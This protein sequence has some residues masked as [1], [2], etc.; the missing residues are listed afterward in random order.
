MADISSITLP[1][2]DTYNFKDPTARASIGNAV[3]SISSVDGQIEI[4][5]AD[6][7][8][9]YIENGSIHA[10]RITD[11]TF[12]NDVQ[13][14]ITQIAMGT[15]ISYK[16]GSIDGVRD[17]S[18]MMAYFFAG[19]MVMLT[20]GSNPNITLPTQGIYVNTNT[21]QITDPTGIYITF[22]GKVAVDFSGFGMGTIFIDCM[23]SFYAE[24]VSGVTYTSYLIRLQ[25]V[26][27]ASDDTTPASAAIDSTGLMT[28]SNGSGTSLFTVQLPLYNGGIT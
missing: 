26:H 17:I 23:A 18:D 25:R 16:S 7:T 11:E 5:H 13:S 4:T 15:E 24:E 20:T 3:T 12:L 22:G 27:L 8:I 6:G 21:P 14:A 10:H 19:Y 9:E 1:N 28:F 2:G